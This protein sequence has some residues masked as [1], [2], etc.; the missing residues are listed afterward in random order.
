M[1]YS[2]NEPPQA[3]PFGERKAEIL[4]MAGRDKLIMLIAEDNED[5]RNYLKKGFENDFEVYAYDNGA[6]AL[7]NVKEVN[8]DLIISDVMMPGINGMELCNRLKADIDTSHIPLILLTARSQAI[9]KVEGLESGADD[10]ITKPFN[11]SVIAARV[12]NLIEGRHKLRLRYQKEIKLDPQNITINNLD[13]AFLTKVLKYVENHIADPDLSVEQLS[14]ELAM[15]KSAFYKKIKSLTNQT[16]VEF[17]RT[18]RVKRAAQLLTQGQLTVSQ[19]AYEVGFM[20]VDYFRKC[21]KEHFNYTP[22][23]HPVQGSAETI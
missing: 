4:K 12:W 19:V 18:I 17:I 6:D 8:P 14:Q 21:F 15:S 20:D 9:F 3:S 5:V 13:E 16:G 22:K 23:E 1:R 10:Y 7:A 11:F 2:D